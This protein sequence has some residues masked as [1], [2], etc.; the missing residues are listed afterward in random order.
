MIVGI[1]VFGHFWYRAGRRLS[2]ARILEVKNDFL[3]L[4][5]RHAKLPLNVRWQDHRL[6]RP[7][8]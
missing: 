5:S 4:E 3:W 7:S 8:R 2:S 1:F 6:A